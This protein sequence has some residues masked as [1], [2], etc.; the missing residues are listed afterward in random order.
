VKRVLLVV[1]AALALAG[2]SD[3]FNPP[4]LPD[5]GKIHYEFAVEVPPYTGD[6]GAAADLAGE[7]PADMALRD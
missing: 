6:L 2:C 7:P 5:L 1:A 3:R 4:P